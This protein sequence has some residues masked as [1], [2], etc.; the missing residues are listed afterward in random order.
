MVPTLLDTCMPNKCFYSWQKFLNSYD[1]YL[2]QLFLNF[3]RGL[4]KSTRQKKVDAYAAVV[5][6]H[7]LFQFHVK[8]IW[9][10]H[11]V[12]FSLFFC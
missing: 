8:D 7:I 4:N 3:Y 10:I 2:W 9:Y 12:M 11:I 5:R 1:L 6:Y